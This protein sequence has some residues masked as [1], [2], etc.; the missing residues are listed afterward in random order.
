MHICLQEHTETMHSWDSTL[1]R[2]ANSPFIYNHFSI[3]NET[4]MDISHLV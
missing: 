4:P 3:Q 2:A 1:D